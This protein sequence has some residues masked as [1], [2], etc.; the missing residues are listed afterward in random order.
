MTPPVLQGHLGQAVIRR[1]GDAG[2]EVAAHEAG[3]EGVRRGGDEVV[4]RAELADACPSTITPTRS[5][6]GG[7]VLEVVGHQQR[8]QRE[9][10]QEPLELRRARRRGCACRGPTAARRRAGSAGSRGQRP[11]EAHPLALAAR[12]LSRA[13]PSPGGR[14]RSARAARRPAPCRRTRRSRA[15]SCAGRAR[16]PGRRSPRARA[17]GG[18]LIRRSR[19]KRTRSPSAIAPRAGPHGA[20]DRAEHRRLPRARGPDQREGLALPTSSASR[21]S[22]CRSGTATSSREPRHEIT[23]FRERRTTAL[24]TTSRAPMASAT[25]KFDVELLVDREGHGLGD[26]LQAAGEHDRGPELADAARERQG[27]ARGEAALRRAGARCA[28]RR[29]RARRRACAR[30]AI[31]SSS[32]LSNAAIAWRR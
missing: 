3:H 30:R 12:E 29:G 24:T 16:T 4:R 6:S 20:G 13:G 5:A 2:Q 23:S 1:A 18:R 8:R 32:R 9:L 15:R 17:S 22:K 21:S 31:R 28:R 27:G 14:S 19:S 7:R 11:R 10:G 26:A 25:S